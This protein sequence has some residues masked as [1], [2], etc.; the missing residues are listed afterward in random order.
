M[1]GILNTQELFLFTG[2]VHARFGDGHYFTDISPENIGGLTKKEL[3]KNSSKISL[4]QLASN[5]FGDARKWR[6]LTHYVVIDVE[7]LDISEPRKNTFLHSS[8]GNLDLSNRIVSSGVT[9]NADKTV[10]KC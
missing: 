4:G 10:P 2:N 8:N 9:L 6:K 7:G 3:P 5:L 1:K